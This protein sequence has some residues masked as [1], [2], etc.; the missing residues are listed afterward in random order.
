MPASVVGE[1]STC[2]IEV[3][4]IQRALRAV[5]RGD[6]PTAKQVIRSLIGLAPARSAPPWSLPSGRRHR[7]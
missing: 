2:S 6:I 3:S 5:E 7:R 1:G 4:Q